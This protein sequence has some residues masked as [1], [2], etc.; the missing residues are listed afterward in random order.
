VT[1]ANTGAGDTGNGDGGDNIVTFPATEAERR[2][3]RKLQQDRERQKLV[4]VFV[5]QDRAL[6]H[7]PNG[8]AYADL[9]IG[10]HRETW[11]IKSKEFRS[12][13]IGYLQR[14]LDRL[15]AEGSIL[16]MG[17]KAA[18]SKTAVNAAI[19]DFEIRAIANTSP[20][21]TV[22]TRVAGHGDDIYID[23]C[24]PN[25]EVI[26][27]T[28]AGWS[29]VADPPVRFRRTRGML[30]LPYPERG[31]AIAALRPFVNVSTDADFAMT[32]AWLLAA[33]RP[34]GPY[35][36]LSLYGEHGSAKSWLIG[37]VL[38]AFIDPHT[39]P[40]TRLPSSSRDLF[41]AAHNT[42]VLMFANVS[43][44]SDAMSDDLCRLST[45]EGAR[46]R[47]L[48][49]DTE[50]A[51]FG[52][53]RPI[54]IE[55]I[56]RTVL[57]MDL[58]S[59]SVV[60][61]IPPLSG[62]ETTRDLRARFE[63][64]QASIFGAL[65]TMMARGIDKLPTTK[66]VNPPRMADF[67]EWGVACGIEDFETIYAANRREAISVMLEHDPLAREVRTLMTRRSQW[68]GTAQDLLDAV[69]FAAG[70]NS[71]QAISDWLRRLAPAL[72]MVG[73]HIVYEPRKKDR[74]PFRIEWVTPVT[75][76]L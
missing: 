57:R 24:N 28:A 53:E 71:T 4:N 42:H 31:G 55:G 12:A 27:I 43:S 76:P 15:V 50:E 32:I 10:G 61:V 21:R 3:M 41:I 26:R 75:A 11:S 25:W 36:A 40:T 30:P 1:P 44:I 65:L 72:R 13:Y 18:M 14:Q 73:L 47:S 69:G 22:H 62:Y 9:I 16:A 63:R 33:M 58:L 20:V 45:G 39:V 52:G 74:R 46:T 8:V 67:A 56:N 64:Q 2:Q 49:T 70:V 6:F 29:I 7:D 38:R 17:V 48:F 35:A 23:L 34:R 19:S 37:Q 66:L 59:R 60:L 54:A 51:L 68:R 5:D